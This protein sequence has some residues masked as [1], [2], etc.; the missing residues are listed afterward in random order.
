[1]RIANRWA[2]G[3]NA[4][5][6]EGIVLKVELE[7]IELILAETPSRQ[8]DFL[9]VA[10]GKAVERRT[11]NAVSQ[12]RGRTPHVDNVNELA[13][14]AELVADNRPSPEEI[15]AELED[16]IRRPELIRMACD[17]VK[18]PQHLEA[19]I[20]RFCHDWPITDSDPNK[21]TLAR[22]FGKSGRQIQNWINKALE[23]MRTA[24]GE[25]K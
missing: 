23:E 18:N 12:H 10:F 9:E 2:R 7:I 21:Q 4:I 16:D 22:R 14:A 5:T 11:I 15:F 24:I 1:V 25:K 13:S 20:L 8:S 6:T 3:F 19:V 17:A